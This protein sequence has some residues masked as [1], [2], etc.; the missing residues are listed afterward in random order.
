MFSI[1]DK[2]E[3]SFVKHIQKNGYTT[4]S[5]LVSFVSE[6]DALDLA[7]KLEIA[8]GFSTDILKEWVNSQCV[9]Y[10]DDIIDLLMHRAKKN[11]RRFSV[12]QTG[13]Y[14]TRLSA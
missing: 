11:S 9:A 4:Q 5:E 2:K 13:Q 6:Q 7:V 8:D 12:V 14:R 3:R 1:W 10:H